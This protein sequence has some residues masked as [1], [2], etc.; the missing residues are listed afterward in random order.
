MHFA[1]SKKTKNLTPPAIDDSMLWKLKELFRNSANKPGAAPPLQAR[2]EYVDANACKKLGDACLAQGQLDDAEQYYLQ[3]LEMVPQLAGACVGLGYI[4]CERELYAQAE[5]TLERALSISPDNADA[6][7]LLGKL[8]QAKSESEAACEHYRRAIES[9]SDLEPAYLSLCQLLMA[10]GRLREATRIVSAGVAAN[11]VS[12]NL[13]FYL[14]NLQFEDGDFPAAMASFERALA[15]EPSRVDILANLGLTL[16]KNKAAM[17]AEEVFKRAL[18]ID[19]RLIAVYLNLGNALHRQGKY[20]EAISVYRSGLA[21]DET[22]AGLL[23]NLGVSLRAQDNAEDEIACYRQALAADPNYAEAYLNLGIALKNQGK[24]DEAM[25]CFAELIARQPKHSGAYVNRGN[26]YCESG[27][28]DLAIEQYD[29]ALG[30]EPNFQAYNNKGSVMLMLGRFDEAVACYESALEANPDMAAAHSSMLFTYN[31]MENRSPAEMLSAAKRFGALVA[32]LASP[33]SEWTSAPATNRRLRVA[34][35]S[36][37]LRNGPVGFF[38]ESIFKAWAANPSRHCELIVYFHNKI[39]DSV[40]ARIKPNCSEWHDVATLS[41]ENLAH[42]IHQDRIDVLIDLDGHTANNR[43]AVFAW[44]PAPVQASWLGY[45]AT[46]GVAAIDYLIADPCTLP[47]GEEINFSEKIWRLPETR[48]CFTAPDKDIEVSP[49]PSLANGYLT[50]GC[51]NNLLKMNEGTVALWSRILTALPASKLFLKAGSLK[52]EATRER[53]LERFAAHGIAGDRMILEGPQQRA[54]Y[55]A[56]YHRVD[57]ALDPF[58][59]TGGATSAETLWMGVPIITLAGEHFV[60]RQG[61][62]LLKN[63]GLSDWVA[64]TPDEYLGLAV[65]HAGNLQQLAQLRAGLRRQVLASPIFDAPRFA[66]HIDEALK[67][68]W[69]QRVGPALK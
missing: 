28:L 57:I 15:I 62:G 20:D 33:F 22:S 35:V 38:A 44:K 19:P 50:F 8:F 18:A 63:A 42:K 3:A 14:G 68:M 29:L 16:L 54:A 67:G 43:L 36:G 45:F 37:E 53:T 47:M 4:Y 65:R 31:Y 61:A 13:L 64:T 7:Y 6:H 2:Q 10:Q 55:L 49:L 39:S 26:I 41:D 1:S 40:T 46:T 32:R 34:F 12:A 21:F 58:P 17:Q 27:H 60:S 23:N 56:A 48:L 59:Y 69:E 24:T 30:I 9:A 66:R 51:F 52:D 11:P 25:S 5:A